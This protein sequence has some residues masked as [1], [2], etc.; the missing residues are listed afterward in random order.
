MITCVNTESSEFSALAER[1]G[2]NP[3]VLEV[4]VAKFLDKYGRMPKLDELPGAN[5]EVYLRNFLDLNSKYNTMPLEL[6]LQRTHTSSPEEAII[7]LNNLYRDL[8]ISHTMIGDKVRINIEKRPS[9]FELRTTDP[10]DFSQLNSTL[11]ITN[12]LED[13]R[14]KMGIPVIQVSEEQ[15]AKSGILGAIPEAGKELAFIFNGKIYV[16]TTRAKNSKE[17]PTHELMHILMG[18]LKMT[19]PDLYMTLVSQVQQ[20]ENYQ[21]L[22][23]E[24]PNRAQSDIDEEL[25]VRE[26]TRML[27]GMDSLY[28]NVDSKI[29]Y[30]VNYEISRALDTMLKGDNSVRIIPEAIRFG[31]PLINLGKTVNSQT[32][33]N[34][35]ESLFDVAQA[36]R[37]MANQRRELMEDGRLKE[38]CD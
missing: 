8:D 31:Q 13:L 16:N 5:S 9:P 29:L 36:H 32:M 14:I 24:F 6:L 4:Q 26:Y 18:A 15:L 35:F 7:T 11:W 30:D 2:L 20:L 3:F 34:Q 21:D 19:N 10:V 12:A 23:R 38:I 17:A 22:A 1:S 27:L 25:F 33:R 37:I 28:K